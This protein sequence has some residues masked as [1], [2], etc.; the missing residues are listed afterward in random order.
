M[1]WVAV[2]SHLLSHSNLFRKFI[3]FWLALCCQLS[4]TLID[5]Q[6]LLK[7]IQSH[8]R[9]FLIHR[10]STYALIM[11]RKS[12]NLTSI[13][14]IKELYRL[15]LRMKKVSCDSRPSCILWYVTTVLGDCRLQLCTVQGMGFA[16]LARVPPVYGLYA[17]IFPG[18]VYY[19]FGTSRHLSIGTMALTAL[20]VG[21][22]VARTVPGMRLDFFS[23][24]L[25]LVHLCYQ[26][27]E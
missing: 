10:P 23:I 4:I 6:S 12:C 17:S 1:A 14:F 13:D 5:I 2:Q 15:L 7:V 20:M 16:L 18:W 21:A 11:S 9:K 19:L 27:S 24:L 3:C 8:S 26:Y 22:V 25:H